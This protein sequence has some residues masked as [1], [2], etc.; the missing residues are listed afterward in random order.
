[1]PPTEGRGVGDITALGGFADRLASDQCLRLVA[2][3][4]LVVEP[5]QRRPG[6]RIERLVAFG[7]AVSRFAASAAPGANLSRTA[8]RTPEV[9]DPVASDFN[10]QAC[11]AG[12]SLCHRRRHRCILV[13]SFIW[14]NVIARWVHD[15]LAGF[16]QRQRAQCSPALGCIQSTD[17]QQPFPK[18]RVTHARLQ[19]HRTCPKLTS[20]NRLRNK[21]DDFLAGALS[22]AGMLSVKR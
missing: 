3:A 6:E 12:S 15:R 5:G 7:T 18:H 1:M 21:S 2:P 11:F 9:L 14:W 13:G 20:F 8:M 22:K 17:L 4:V 16:C 19:L 10:E